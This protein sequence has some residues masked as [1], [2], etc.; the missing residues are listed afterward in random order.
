MAEKYVDYNPNK[1]KGLP[2]YEIQSKE[3][4]PITA[5]VTV[6]SSA[7]HAQAAMMPLYYLVK[8]ADTL[9]KKHIIIKGSDKSG[10]YGHA[11]LPG[12]W[13]GSTSTGAR[14][15][16]AIAVGSSVAQ[17]LKGGVAFSKQNPE[18]FVSALN[19]NLAPEYST[20]VTQYT[21]DEYTKMKAKLFLSQSGKSG[22]AI[23]PD[24]DIISVF[25]KKGS[26]EGKYALASAI[27]NGGT[28]LDCF[29][30]FLPQFYQQF[31]FSEY[32]RWTW[33]DQYAPK[34]W[35]I[36]RFD[37]PD[38]VLMKLGSESAKKEITKITKGTEQQRKDLEKEQKKYIDDVFGGPL[39][40]EEKAQIG[41]I[42]NNKNKTVI[43]KGGKGSGHHG[44]GGLPG[45]WGGS[46]SSGKAKAN[47]PAKAKPKAAPKKSK[48]TATI[49]KKPKAKPESQ[50]LEDRSDLLPNLPETPQETEAQISEYQQL[51]KDIINSLPA[52][53]QQALLDI[54]E[55]VKTGTPTDQIYKDA[56]GNWT[57]ERQALHDK[58]VKEMIGEATPVEDTPEVVITG[59]LPGSG[60]S[61][62]LK[63]RGS[64]FTNHV[65]VD[66]DKVKQMLP[67]YE[68]WNASLLH[69]ESSEISERVMREA[70][71][72]NYNVIYDATLKTESSARRIVNSFEER[73][74]DSKIIF[75]QVPMATAMN[76]A[77]KRFFG[78]TQ[79]YV[80][81]S[82][83]ATHDLKNLG[84]LESLKGIADSW[85]LWDNSREGKPPILL[86]R[87]GKGG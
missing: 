84:T 16:A 1:H 44:H 73:G 5:A 79:R 87:G 51:A 36:E 18:S 61:T 47:G 14:K 29:D 7:T 17:G 38:V 62:V 32:D 64:E 70:V 82:Y 31:G 68:G 12:V 75:T 57:P 15:A 63:Q 80:P 81:L 4:G 6:K 41:E 71:S 35:N 49:T 56:D 24:G 69:E 72:G 66:S 86:G 2:L 23:K 48:P 3:M 42:I 53:K 65:H 25:S 40:D 85:E 58:I 30:G 60:K 22:Y 21:A 10:H 46:S 28:K 8:E 78:T 74:Y 27:A 19:K 83:L 67:E 50:I 9:R 59:G 54:E 45:V 55:K 34:G 37:S 77:V 20:F 76:R 33:D 43:I 39:T 13:G 11:G 26:G 52:D